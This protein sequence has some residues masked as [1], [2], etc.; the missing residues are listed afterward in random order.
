MD[1]LATS[2]FPDEDKAAG[3]VEQ[4]DLRP[5]SMISKPRALRDDC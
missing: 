2:R 3:R 4:H 1:A 5:D